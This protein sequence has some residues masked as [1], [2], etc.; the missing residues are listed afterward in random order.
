MEVMCLSQGLSA[1]FLSNHLIGPEAMEGQGERVKEAASTP[2]IVPPRREIGKC[3]LL[4]SME[5]IV[6]VKTTRRIL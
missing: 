6:E 4:M 1:E 3:A 2:G 5:C